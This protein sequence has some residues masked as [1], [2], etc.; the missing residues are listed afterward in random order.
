MTERKDKLHNDNGPAYSTAGLFFGK[1]SHHPGL[2]APLQPRFGFLRLLGFPK[3]KIAVER[4]GDLWMRQS[5]STQA[6]SM[7]S[8]CRLSS[9]T[10]EWLFK[11]THYGLFWL[12]AKIHQGNTTG[13]R[14]IQDGWI[15]FGQPS[16]IPNPFPP[17]NHLG[18][19]PDLTSKTS[20]STCVP[21][22]GQNSYR[23]FD[24]KICY[25]YIITYCNKYTTQTKSTTTQ[26]VVE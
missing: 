1:A 11:D 13:T 14:D 21:T 5:H 23:I 24:D 3:A 17:T 12:A 4:Y 26:K 22:Q 19:Y 15:D 9:P 16:Y 6:Q 25:I 2:S 20:E 18:V 7:A 8:H 10:G